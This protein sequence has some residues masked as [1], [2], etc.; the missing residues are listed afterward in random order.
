MRRNW[1]GSFISLRFSAV[2]PQS[3]VNSFHVQC[4]LFSVVTRARS[5]PTWA[6][7]GSPF[8]DVEVVAVVT[9][10]DDVLAGSH[11]ALEHGVNHLLHLVLWTDRG[12]RRAGSRPG[13]DAYGR[14]SRRTG[15]RPGGTIDPRSVPRPAA[16]R[17][18][19]C[20][21]CDYGTKYMSR[22]LRKHKTDIFH[23]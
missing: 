9:L 11:L 6:P 1:L 7:T 8:D 3:M 19:D 2:A 13:R 5:G 12:R 17:P 20:Q 22:T 18:A 10:L 21:L 14:V 15:G 4:S 23:T 16:G